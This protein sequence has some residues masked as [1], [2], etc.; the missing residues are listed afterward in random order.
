VNDWITKFGS[1]IDPNA[2]ARIA[3]DCRQDAGIWY[4]NGGV[5]AIICEFW[6]D[7]LAATIDINIE[8]KAKTEA[9]ADRALAVQQYLLEKID[10]LEVLK[11]LRQAE[12]TAAIKGGCPLL[13]S[14]DGRGRAVGRIKSIKMAK[15]SEINVEP[16]ID[17]LTIAAIDSATIFSRTV[18]GTK[19]FLGANKIIPF[20]AKAEIDSDDF[21]YSDDSSLWGLPWIG[22]A[23]IQAAKQYEMGLLASNV[24]LQL[25]SFQEI[26]IKG[27][28]EKLSGADSLA[29]QEE[30]R[31]MLTFLT[32]VS[33]NL[34]IRLNDMDE[35]ETKIVERSLA[36]VSDVITA[37]RNNLLIHSPDIPEVYLFQYREKGG[38]NQGAAKADEER[39]DARAA[40]LWQQRWY[41]PIRQIIR[42]LLLSSEC[43]NSDFQLKDIKI[44]R[45]SGYSPR[46]IEAA[47]VAKIE[48]ETEVARWEFEQKVMAAK[49]VE[50]I[51]A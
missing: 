24:L 35:S 33:S 26:S 49:K 15:R 38:I 30:L 9:A 13:V 51:P 8:P 42:I 46:P 1:E 36:G 27:L 23:T 20:V 22:T 31:S 32:T 7:R 44:S 47:T 40:E 6:A 43:P 14:Q 18:N 37:L 16:S 17:D 50:N 11:T 10:D 34:S 25:K 48:L 3:R 21:D 12:I 29:K 19:V 4:E 45:R 41:Q 39:V 5:A 2:T 28:F